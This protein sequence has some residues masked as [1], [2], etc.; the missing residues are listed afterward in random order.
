MNHVRRSTR[1]KTPVRSTLT[2]AVLMAM[3]APAAFAQD[4]AVAGFPDQTQCAGA[5]ATGTFATAVGNLAIASGANS[6]AFG[7]EAKAIGANSTAAGNLANARTR[8]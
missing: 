2:A 5:T 3:A 6:S 4:C 8:P 1:N 7:N